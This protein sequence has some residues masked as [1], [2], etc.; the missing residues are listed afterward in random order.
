M[1]NQQ[2]SIGFGSDTS[3]LSG[4]ANTINNRLGNFDLVLENTSTETVFVRIREYT[5]LRSVAEGGASTTSTSGY[6]NASV[7]E[8]TLVGGGVKTLSLCLT[9]Q[10]I[11]FFGSGSSGRTARVNI[12]TVMRNLANLRGADISIVPVG[13]KGYSYDLG[14][15]VSSFTSPGW[16]SIN[17]ATGDVNQNPQGY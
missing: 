11:G 17:P 6:I 13:R 15:N 7:A 1:G 2:S 9:S 8:A 14:F 16:G 12:S 3:V 5:G 4:Y 10:Q